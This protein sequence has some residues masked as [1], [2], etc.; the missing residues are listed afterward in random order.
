MKLLGHAQEEVEYVW[1]PEVVSVQCTPMG[2]QSYIPKQHLN[3]TPTA[4]LLT[5]TWNVKI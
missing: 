2:T 4:S 5:P 1:G 3:V